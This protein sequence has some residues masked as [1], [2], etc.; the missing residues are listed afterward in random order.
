MIIEITKV[1]K[2]ASWIS[3]KLKG[4]S[5]LSLR[6][7]LNCL[8]RSIIYFNYERFIGTIFSKFTKKFGIIGKT[9][10]VLFKF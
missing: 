5:E 2:N 7:L 10:I 1:C 6:R 9:V 4:D 3:R 8:A